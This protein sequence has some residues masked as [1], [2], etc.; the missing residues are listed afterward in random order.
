M[1]KF[2]FRKRAVFDEFTTCF[3]VIKMTKLLS[4]KRLSTI[5]ALVDEKPR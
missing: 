4:K 3:P 1:C 5:L 2:L